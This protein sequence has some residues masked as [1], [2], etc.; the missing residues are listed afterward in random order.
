MKGLV[1]VVE[2]QNHRCTI[3]IAQKEQPQGRQEHKE[4]V[5]D[6]LRQGERREGVAKAAEDR[7]GD[8]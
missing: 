3:A 7:G 4:V 2:P 5:R 8:Q 6:A 1:A